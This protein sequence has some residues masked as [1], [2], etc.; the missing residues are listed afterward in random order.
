[1]SANKVRIT[2]SGGPVEVCSGVNVN[3]K[4]PQSRAFGEDLLTI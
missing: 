3:L 2:D 4:A 1:V